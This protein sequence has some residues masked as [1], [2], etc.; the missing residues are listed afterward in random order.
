GLPDGDGFSIACVA[1]IDAA[2][3]ARRLEAYVVPEVPD[4]F[5]RWA[6]PF[7][8]DTERAVG[9]TD[10]PGGCVVMQPWYFAAAATDVLSS[11]S[12]GT[13]AYGMY[14]N[15]KSGNQGSIH[16]DGEIVGWD[17][18]PGGEPDAGGS[19]AEVLLA[20]LYAYEA[21]AYCCAHVGLRPADNKAFTEPDQW[22]LLPDLSYRRA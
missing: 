7:G 1:G 8:A 18:H 9:V 19:T 6:D 21:V 5:D 11:L 3:V 13:V 2:E 4:V 15:P 22:I 17:L 16:H 20:H 14:A 10:V 12:A